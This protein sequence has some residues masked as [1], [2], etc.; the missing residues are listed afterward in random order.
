MSRLAHAVVLSGGWR[1]RL[2]AGIAGATGALAMAPVDAF[3]ALIVPLTMAVWLIDGCAEAE[4]GGALSGRSLARSLLA[5]ADAGWWL[6]FGYFV[7]GLWWLGSAFL[8]EADR[9]AWALPFGV[10]GLPAYLALYTGFGFALARLM[11]TT[12]PLRILVLATCLTGA[13]WLRGLLLTGFPWNEFGMALGGN[14]VL[15]Q[16]ASVV[17]LHGLTLLAVAMAA[18]P[19]TLADGGGRPAARFA[20]SLA[21]AV[22]L[23]GIAGYGGFRLTRAAPDDVAGVRLRVMQP[24]TR[25]DSDFTY[26]N[27]EQVVRHYLEL[28]DRATSPDT[29]GL[30]AVTHLVWPESAFPFIVSRDAEALSTIGAALPPGAMLITGAARL[31]RG[32]DDANGRP[33]PHYY[34]AIQTIASGGSIVGSYDKVHL[35]PFGEFLPLE[36]LLT[37]LGVTRFVDVP[38]GFQSGTSRRILTV[39]GL[40]PVAAI[41]CYEAIFSGEVVPREARS[42]P[43][44]P[45]LLL[46]VTNDAWFGST[47]GPAQHFAQ[48]RLRAIEEG[49]PLVRSASTGVSAI[50]D[51]YGRV[52]AALPIGAENVIDGALPGALPPSLFARFGNMVPLCLLVISLLGTLVLRGLP[53]RNVSR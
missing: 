39:P 16:A 2:I 25:I 34:N 9:F 24:N 41:V 21:A 19:A 4:S 8:A 7:A 6:G 45:G 18:A 37:R 33:V 46:N 23:L 11:W 32:P 14:L 29:P 48:A 50:V 31:E 51:S 26:A 20:P 27:K 52:R 43:D 17:G 38:G 53:L 3:A 47:P 44:R 10:L 36:G 40:P 35:V 22:L 15:G 28:S 12:G 30:S 1:R 42:G 13:E 5:A 49:L